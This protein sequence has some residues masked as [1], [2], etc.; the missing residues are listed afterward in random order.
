[1]LFPSLTAAQAWTT[2]SMALVR[3]WGVEVDRMLAMLADLYPSA[4]PGPLSLRADTIFASLAGV[5]PRGANVDDAR[6]WGHEVEA[7]LEACRPTGYTALTLT[8]RARVIFAPGAG[9]VVLADVLVWAAEIVAYAQGLN[10]PLAM[11]GNRAG[12][13]IDF[14]AR[15]TAIRVTEYGTLALST[16]DAL[17]TVSRASTASYIDSAGLLQF[18]SSA[19]LRYDYHPTT[20]APLGALI[21][22]AR[23]NVTL[24]C[25][26]C[27]NAAWTKSNITAAKNQ[28]GVDGVASSASSLTATATNGTCLQAITLASS[29]RFQSAYIKR[30]VGTGNVQMTTDGGSTWATVTITSSWARY[31]IPT[32][33]LANPS[34]GFRLATSGDSIAVDFAQNE[35]GTF[36]SSAILTT[37]VAVQR[38][39]DVVSVLLAGLPVSATAGTLFVDYTVDR[40]ESSYLLA[41]LLSDATANEF[42]GSGQSTVVYAQIVDGGVT[43]ADIFHTLPAI[44]AQTRHAMAWAPN[45]IAS[46]LNAG[47]VG[48]DSV[49]TMPT[50]TKLEIGSG[51][52][53]GF[54]FGHMRRVALYPTR[55]T[56]APLQAITA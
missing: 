43:Q 13:V 26:D 49:A 23:T 41:G 52:G 25:R 11:L 18:A 53:G 9:G 22:G 8:K 48:T 4:F 56:N 44:G 50:V 34:V 39:A 42:F 45:D 14:V 28:T 10:T 40:V 1:M 46:C 30:L 51:L 17:L 24:W 36:A 19:V 16:P 3:A 21:E 29:A 47:T 5:Q 6:R 37:T 35:D 27:T 38:A 32:Q 2:R 20:F 55:L 54:L 7:T 31:S 12:V 33:T 15:K